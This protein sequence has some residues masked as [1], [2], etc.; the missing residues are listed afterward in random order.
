MSKLLIDERPLTVL[1]S[2]VKVVGMERA[3][4]LQQIHWLMQGRNNGIEHD[5]E[6]W[7]WGTYEEWCD[8][9]FPF[10][11]PDTL[12]KHLVKLEEKGFVFSVQIKGF[13]R[14]KHYR[15]NQEKV[16]E[17]EAAMRHDHATSKRKDSV[18]PKRH[19]DA[20]SMRDDH[21][22]S[23]GHNGI[24]SNR[25]DDTEL[26]RDDHASS[27]IT[28]TSTKTS[29]EK[30]V[31]GIQ[32]TNQ[33]RTSVN[34]PTTHA[35]AMALLLKV[36]MGGGTAKRLADAV[37]FIEIR[38]QVAAWLPDYGRGE[39]KVP[40][41]IWRIESGEWSAPDLSPEFRR[42]DLY[43]Q[44]RTPEEVQ[45][46]EAAEAETQARIAELDARQ[47]VEL[48]PG[49][50]PMAPAPT[51]AQPHPLP[52]P[53]PTDDPW[54]ICLSE[55]SPSLPGVAASYLIGSRLEAAG[56]VE[57]QNGKRLPL[58]RVLVGANAAAGI[59]WLSAQAGP[60]IRR[61]L[62]GILGKPV[63]IEIV[64]EEAVADGV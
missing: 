63:L 33:P 47:D 36:G 43:R 35:L 37:S 2:L 21:A 23:N 32:P 10:W 28:K 14:T 41:L 49:V 20:T 40:A 31:G 39:A 57:G 16:E 18:F 25:D 12:R 1:P 42:S 45:A 7:V 55:L 17:I 30:M 54:A 24:A 34:D 51:P 27:Y 61:K 53:M 13:D 56:E 11:K 62:G 6:K 38:R 52:A 9:Y 46:D 26:M 4:I 59:T 48:M 22:A 60:A 5:G 58:Y 44:F 29:K 15:I 8:E 19:D 64:A 3:V 50:H